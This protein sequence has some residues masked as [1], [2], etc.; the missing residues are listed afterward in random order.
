MPSGWID[1]C[2]I[3]Q[4]QPADVLLPFEWVLMDCLEAL[5]TRNLC[6]THS[7]PIQRRQ[8]HACSVVPVVDLDRAERLEQITGVLCSPKFLFHA[9]CV[10]GL[11]VLFIIPPAAF[12][13]VFVCCTVGV[14]PHV[15]IERPNASRE[16]GVMRFIV[17]L[18]Q[19]N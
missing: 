7:P 11:V 19:L 5:S 2:V 12:Q 15:T 13:L 6:T 9:T 14:V 3:G 4:T 10:A 8:A 18:T 17:H 16:R 1:A